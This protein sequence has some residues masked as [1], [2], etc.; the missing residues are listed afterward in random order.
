MQKE[1]Q[2]TPTLRQN[3][4]SSRHME[5]LVLFS[6]WP[7]TLAKVGARALKFNAR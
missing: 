6:P 5:G 2:H 3:P 1:Q 4:P 7:T